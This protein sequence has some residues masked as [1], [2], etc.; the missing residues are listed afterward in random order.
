MGNKLNG[1]QSDFDEQDFELIGFDKKLIDIN[2]AI[3]YGMY[4]LLS[5]R[6]KNSPTKTS[7]Q[8][9]LNMLMDKLA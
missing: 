9:R 3:S 5:H 4:R 6:F 2:E 8:L 7:T 1:F